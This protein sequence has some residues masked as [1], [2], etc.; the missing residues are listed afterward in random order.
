MSNINLI[1]KNK[2]IKLYKFILFLFPFFL[3]SGPFL[4]DLTISILFLIFA[5]KTIKIIKKNLIIKNLFYFFLFFYLYLI[6]NSF[7]SFNPIISLKSSVPYIRMIFLSFFLALLL[8]QIKF[9]FNI[10]LLSIISCY[11]VLLI[12]SIYQVATGYNFFG[13]KANGERISSFFGEKLVMGSFVSRTLPVALSIFFFTKFKYQEPLKICVVFISGILIYLSAERLS[14]VF[15]FVTLVLFTFVPFSKKRVLIILLLFFSFSSLLYS[16]KPNSFNRL[17]FHTI[18]QVKETSYFGFSYRHE[19][20]LITAF[21]L[22]NDSKLFGHGLKSFRN[23]C[24]NNKYAPTEKII[25]DNTIYSPADGRIFFLD[26]T[27]TNQNKFFILEKNYD[28]ELFL[29]IKNEEISNIP[30]FKKMYEGIYGFNFFEPFNKVYVKHN[31]SIKLGDP[32]GYSYQFIDGCNTHPHNLYFEFLSEL[33][34]IGLI[35]LLIGFFYIFTH[36]IITLKNIFLK[37][38][39]NFHY[40]FLFSLLGIILSLFPLFPSGS[41]FNNWL[42]SILYFNLGIIL[43]F[44]LFKKK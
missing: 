18:K 33:G 44:I 28:N 19:L 27:I 34:L 37:N 22:F 15:Y 24:G 14:L 26:E 31:D 43:S 42:S 17:Y 25:R 3:I 32:I 20:H 40:S 7:F 8:N 23:L 10:L 35:F 39:V 30:I 4:P 1:D 11:V 38:N 6:L 21:N 29:K 2:N 16:I 13:F 41:F 5:L 12:D 36:F 9:F